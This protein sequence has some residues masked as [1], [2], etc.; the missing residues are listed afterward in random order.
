MCPNMTLPIPVKSIS[1]S[2]SPMPHYTSYEKWG[3]HPKAWHSSGLRYFFHRD[4]SLAGVG[5]V[6]GAQIGF[7]IEVSGVGERL[8]CSTHLSRSR[9]RTLLMVLGPAHG[10]HRCRR[11]HRPSL[12]DCSLSNL[13]SNLAIP[14]LGFLQKFTQGKLNHRQ[15]AM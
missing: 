13:E 4:M 11:S 6:R 1:W 10:H 2:H 12:G 14:K 3:P 15:D 9:H 5:C 7:R 8:A